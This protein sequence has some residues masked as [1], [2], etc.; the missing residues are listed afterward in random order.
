MKTRL[1]GGAYHHPDDLAADIRLVFA[2]ARLFNPP[3]S[4]VHIM[5]AT[6]AEAFEGKWAATV[7]PKIAE[8]STACE[9]EAKKARQCLCMKSFRLP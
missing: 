3:A 7:G 1:E 5:A 2:N 8:A 6:L 4:D 9:A